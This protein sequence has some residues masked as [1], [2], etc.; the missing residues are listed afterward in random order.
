MS[1]LAVVTGEQAVQAFSKLGFFVARM[2]GSHHV[3]KREGHRYLLS[4]PV[5]AGQTLKPGTLR[6]LIRAAGITPDEFA[7]LLA[8]VRT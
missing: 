4:V 8:R 1:R 5:H 6:G 2:T 7:D 3:M